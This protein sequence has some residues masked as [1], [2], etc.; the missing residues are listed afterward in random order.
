MGVIKTHGWFGEQARRRTAPDAPL[1]MAAD[2]WLLASGLTS[3]THHRSL[4][5]DSH[6]HCTATAMVTHQPRLLHSH[7]R[8]HCTAT[9]VVT[10]HPRLLHS[11]GRGHCT[12]TA[13]A[14][15]RPLY[16]HGHSHGRP[17]HYFYPHNPQ[18]TNYYNHCHH[19]RC[20]SQS[21]NHS[22]KHMFIAQPPQGLGPN[23]YHNHIHACN[24]ATLHDHYTITTY[25]QHH[26]T[27]TV[28][29]RRTRSCNHKHRLTPPPPLR[30]AC[31]GLS[32]AQGMRKW[33]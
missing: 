11:H 22:P 30:L 10:A 18:P 14:P 7:G 12:A 3:T 6:G 31:L 27:C 1:L 8:G 25:H 23:N 28:A 15:S 17:R 24:H 5:F 4:H 2:F 21:A 33:P 26:N 29:Q 19:P 16:G 20:N 32:A 9:V 13:T